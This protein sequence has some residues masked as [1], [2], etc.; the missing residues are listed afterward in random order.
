MLKAAFAVWNRRIAPVFDVA[1]QVRVVTAESGRI[2]CE[3]EE[4]L[5][6]DAGSGKVLKL[7]ELGVDTLVCG[8]ISRSLQGMIA[9]YGIRTV[10]FVAGDLRRIVEAWLAGELEKRSFAMP[11]CCAIDRAPGRQAQL[12]KQE[13]NRMN[14]RG[15]GGSGMGGG[16]GGSGQGMGRGG[17]GLGRMQGPKAGGPA[18]ECVCPKCGH[19]EPH[20]RGI[21]CVDRQCPKCGSAMTRE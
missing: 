10:P 18:G 2:V 17:R 16:R 5:P 9:A 20:M 12:A 11:G 7:T 1:R 15:K 8:A 14:G 13:A 3:T 19:R 6:D 21:P 4:S